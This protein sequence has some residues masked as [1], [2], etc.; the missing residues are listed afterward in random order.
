MGVRV[1][2]TLPKS[3]ILS[4]LNGSYPTYLFQTFFLAVQWWSCLMLFLK[5]NDVLI[6]LSFGLGLLDFNKAVWQIMFGMRM[7]MR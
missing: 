4:M 1:G 2:V 7:R 5:E 6:M 3:T